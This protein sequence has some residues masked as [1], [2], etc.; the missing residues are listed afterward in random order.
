VPLR[1]QGPIEIVDRATQLLRTRA[2]DV[3]VISLGVNIP[4]WLILAAALRD[5]WARG[6]T[7]NAQWF[8]SSVLPE[9]FLFATSGSGSNGSTLTF[10]LGRALPSIG[11]A[12]TGAAAGH[13]VGAWSRGQELTG[14]QALQL[15]ARRGHKLL[16]LWA[17][18]HILEIFTGVGLVLG[19]LI[20]G[21]A[22]PL[23]AIESLSV[24]RTIS[25]SWS[26]C[27]SQLH[28][29]AAAVGVATFI[30]ALIGALLAG[31]PLLFLYS[32]ADRWVDLGGTATVSLAGVLPHALLDPLLALSMALL[33][34]DLKVRV[35]GAD[36]TDEL[37]ALDRTHA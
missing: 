34:L 30:S 21:I 25:R 18:V 19:P 4:M 20:F 8:W 32:V 1:P 27:I 14:T 6:L 35:E 5:E 12:I 2:R 17:I 36:L 24:G 28:R 26:L 7:A 9:P 16:A 13:L 31:A 10:V 15:V 29:T 33:A 3:L 22:A 37:E 23:W 11:L